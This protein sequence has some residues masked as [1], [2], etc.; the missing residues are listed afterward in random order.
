MPPTLDLFLF[1]VGLHSIT[2]AIRKAPIL[3]RARNCKTQ[4]EASYPWPSLYFLIG[5]TS[6][7]IIC[8]A[9]ILASRNE[10]LDPKNIINPDSFSK[11]ASTCRAIVNFIN[12]IGLLA[13]GSAF[14]Q[15]LCKLNN[16]KIQSENLFTLQKGRWP[17]LNFENS[18]QIRF[19]SCISASIVVYI[20]VSPKTPPLGF[21]YDTG[22]YHLPFVNHIGL[23]G[24]SD[25]LA[26]LDMRYGFF[27]ANLIGQ[28]PFQLPFIRLEQIS[29]SLN[30]LYLCALF[31]F[32]CDV[33]NSKITPFGS[34]SKRSRI[35]AALVFV[36]ISMCS[37]S[38]GVSEF[39]LQYN[40]ASFNA[41]FPIC[42]VGLITIYMITNLQ[43]FKANAIPVVLIIFYSP[44]IKASGITI[45]LVALTG[46]TTYILLA[47]KNTAM[48]YLDQNM[49][50]VKVWIL[51]NRLELSIVLT[52]LIIA[53]TTCISFNKISSGYPFYPST[54][55]GN[56]EKYGITQSFLEDYRTNT[57]LEW[58]RAASPGSYNNSPLIHNWFVDYASNHRGFLTLFL[59]LG[60]LAPTAAILLYLYPVKSKDS[61]AFDTIASVLA[62]LATTIMLILIAMPPERRFYMWLAPA[63]IYLGYLASRQFPYLNKACSIVLCFSLAPAL[64]WQLKDL[65]NAFL[66]YHNIPRS[67]YHS[68]TKKSPES[69]FWSHYFWH[70]NYIGSPKV[71]DQ[72]WTSLPPCSN[73]QI[74][75]ANK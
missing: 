11:G 42:I 17:T 75:Q 51:L 6:F 68:A 58:A 2:E 41:D 5:L 10:L 3:S 65:K 16:T 70:N 29:P 9:V 14:A 48:K 37:F 32:L 23:L 45:C 31:Y 34:A 44:L 43:A 22:L 7:C 15:S 1:A 24:L 55:L 54:F 25:G 59:W 38:M 49:T 62:G 56:G 4:D 18:D 50:E 33:F 28:I 66:L 39:T 57:I 53:Y 46:L 60:P 27:N 73:E 26:S 47:R 19:L 21:V 13:L 67:S 69:S 36:I 30:I 63:S 64:A 35:L 8:S 52:M 72:C 20:L 71:S 74:R 61:N 12:V 40:L